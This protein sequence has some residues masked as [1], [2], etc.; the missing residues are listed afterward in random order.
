MKTIGEY[1]KSFESI[2]IRSLRQYTLTTSVNLQTRILELLA[3]LIFL[4]VDYCL[5]DSDK[6]FINYV[7]KQ[8]EQLEQKRPSETSMRGKANAD[9]EHVGDLLARAY[10]V[11]VSE[12]FDSETLIAD[13]L[14][15]F[16]LDTM[17][18]K[19][20]ANVNSPMSACLGAGGSSSGAAYRVSAASTGVAL[21]GTPLVSSL[22]FKQQEHQRLHTII[23]KLFDF[24]IILS[25]EKKSQPNPASTVTTSG[26]PEL[27]RPVSLITI[28]EIIQ[29]CDNLIASE[30]S[31]HT[32]A[33]PA[34][35]PLVLDLFV[36]RSSSNDD[37]RDLEMQHEVIVNTMLRLVNYPQIWPLLSLVLAKYKLDN[38]DRWKKCSRQ[39][40]D[41]LF[42]SMRSSNANSRLK[43]SEFN[44]GELRAI[45]R[46]SRGYVPHV[47]SLKQLFL[48][49]NWLAPQVFRP[50]DFIILSLFE[51]CR[52]FFG[53]QLT[54]TEINNL[55]CVLIVH[56]YL[57]LTN[58]TEDQLLRRLH[59]LCPQIIELCE[60]QVFVR[61]RRYSD[62]R[63]VY[64]LNQ[65]LHHHN[66]HNQRQN[67]NSKQ[68]FDADSVK[69][70]DQYPRSSVIHRIS[71]LN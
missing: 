40:C 7:L 64:P 11:D 16:D 58:A 3:Q 65:H 59:H 32:H 31:P 35:R 8:F 41:A 23:P 36:H 26:R 33:I 57:L 24:L 19:L 66:H 68:T 71:N 50:I 29:L 6:V 42:D 45:R 63:S 12:N 5:L 10:S 55:M 46:Y 52:P 18:N 20:H 38:E 39:I 9:E 15:P 60:G 28:P 44:G 54:S 13:P 43:F 48:L 14:N 21:T 34:L 27:V 2:V 1:I 69:S 4:K 61:P 37:A 51:T 25:H 53:G 22:Y 17:L 47:E 56:V 49:F 30:N 67:P 62:V 70:D